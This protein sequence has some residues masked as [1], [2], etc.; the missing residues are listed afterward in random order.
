MEKG[1]CESEGACKVLKTQHVLSSEEVSE[2]VHLHV[3]PV[4]S[5]SGVQVVNV[6]VVLLM[7]KVHFCTD[8]DHP[9]AAVTANP[10]MQGVETGPIVV[11]S[12]IK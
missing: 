5:S 12:S 1:I 10:Q 4:G 9:R 2:L 11:L 3:L 8:G 6:Q 7:S